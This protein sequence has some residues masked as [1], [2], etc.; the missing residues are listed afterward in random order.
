[1]PPPLR[2]VVRLDFMR[3]LPFL[4]AGFWIDGCGAGIVL[5]LA[6]ASHIEVRGMWGYAT[7]L[8]AVLLALVALV[9]ATVRV[10]AAKSEIASENSTPRPIA[11]QAPEP[12]ALVLA[13]KPLING[14]DIVLG[15]QVTES[16]GTYTHW[17][18]IP[19]RPE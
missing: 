17:L 10:T 2:E 18:P 9:I 11:A 13:W 12:A 4:L 14:W 16:A 7:G 8:I 6:I 1:M 5:G 3:Y 19:P 15:R